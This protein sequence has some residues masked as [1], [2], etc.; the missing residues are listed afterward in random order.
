MII[1][2]NIH[3]VKNILSRFLPATKWEKEV[4]NTTFFTYLSVSISSLVKFLAIETNNFFIF[5]DFAF[6]IFNA[7]AMVPDL[8]CFAL[9]LAH[10]HE[11]V[12]CGK[13]IAKFAYP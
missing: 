9:F 12:F 10:D 3:K 13:K 11:S 5:F 8:A 2:T 1:S 6:K 7:G 4:A